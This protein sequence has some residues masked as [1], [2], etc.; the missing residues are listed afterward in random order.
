MSYIAPLRLSGSLLEQLPPRAPLRLLREAGEV[1]DA[2]V[3]AGVRW[4]KDFI[5]YEE[6][7]SERN[8]SGGG[9]RHTTQLVRVEAGKRLQ[10]VRAGIGMC[11]QVRLQYF[12]VNEK[13]YT[14]AGVLLHPAMPRQTASSNLKANFIFLLQQ[15]AERFAVI[16]SVRQKI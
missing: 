8:G 3:A 6:G 4:R 13:S 12:L 11:G 15:L 1:G 2:E 14:A 9:D 5:E 7:Y 10:A 16:D